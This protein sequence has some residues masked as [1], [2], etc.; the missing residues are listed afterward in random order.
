[1]RTDKCQG[2]PRR[3]GGGTAR[4][5]PRA[6]ARAIT[7]RAS[8]TTLGR[9]AELQKI[10]T[11]QSHPEMLRNF[12]VAE[13]QAL[14]TDRN[15]AAH[16]DAVKTALVT[17]KL[18]RLAADTSAPRGTQEQAAR[19]L[20]RLNARKNHVNHRDLARLAREALARTEQ[21]TKRITSRQVNYRSAAGG[22]YRLRRLL[23]MLNE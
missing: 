12:A 11:D 23:L 17:T 14:D 5:L 20:R 16:Y 8:Y 18:E 3:Y 1:M 7:G 22:K 21:A 15:V 10:A 4:R 13:L 9:I 6:A 2:R 19:E